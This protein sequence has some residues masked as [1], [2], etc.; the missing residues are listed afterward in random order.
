VS[1]T[2]KREDKERIHCHCVGNVAHVSIT[3]FIMVQ[4]SITSVCVTAIY[5]VVTQPFAQERDCIK[6]G[7]VMTALKF[8]ELIMSVRVVKR[9][10]GKLKGNCVLICSVS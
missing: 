3:L 6:T 9:D 1:C 5:K 7:H 8:N 4:H 10:Y 2:E